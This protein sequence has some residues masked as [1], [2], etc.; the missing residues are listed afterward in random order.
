[1]TTEELL[2]L[3]DDELLA[4]PRVVAAAKGLGV[5]L[6]QHELIARCPKHNELVMKSLADVAFQMRDACLIKDLENPDDPTWGDAVA[7]VTGGS[8]PGYVDPPDWIIASVLSWEA[9]G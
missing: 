9:R 1:M 5:Q 6:H 8:D 7:S 2:A 4:N 3:T